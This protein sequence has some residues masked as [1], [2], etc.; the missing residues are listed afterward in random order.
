MHDNELAGAWIALEPTAPQQRR[1]QARV[2][3]WLEARQTSLA[4]EW[5]GLLKL[6]PLAGLGYGAV[7]TCLVLFATPLSWVAFSVL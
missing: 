7:A 5:W 3:G 1:M 2:R 4:Q 6:S